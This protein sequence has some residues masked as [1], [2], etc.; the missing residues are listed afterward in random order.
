MKGRRSAV[1]PNNMDT[2]IQKV[3]KKFAQNLN[4]SAVP[5]CD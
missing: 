1:L 4:N 3:S 5:R 2:T